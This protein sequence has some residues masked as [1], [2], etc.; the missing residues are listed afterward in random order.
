MKF[1]S[2]SASQNTRLGRFKNKPSTFCECRSSGQTDKHTDGQETQRKT[3]IF[4]RNKIETV[5]L[6]LPPKRDPLFAVTFLLT[7]GCI[8]VVVS[9]WVSLTWTTVRLAKTASS[10]CHEVTLSCRMFPLANQG[11]SISPSLV[12]LCKLSRFIIDYFKASMQN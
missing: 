1:V 4:S 11:N 12:L 2:F 8:L 6:I 5:G 7:A 9:L 3:C 10:H